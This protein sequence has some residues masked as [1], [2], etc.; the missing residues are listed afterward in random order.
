MRLVLNVGEQRGAAV[1]VRRIAHR[2]DHLC[3]RRDDRRQN[4]EEE[5]QE[6]AEGSGCH[7]SLGRGRRRPPGTS[8]EPRRWTSA[9]RYAVSAP[10][11]PA[12][13]AP[14]HPRRARARPGAAVPPR[15]AR[16]R[17][18]PAPACRR[19]R[20]ARRAT[21]LRRR[22]R[23]QGRRARRLARAPHRAAMR[24][25]ALRRAHAPAAPGIRLRH[26]PHHRPGRRDEH[27]DLC[28]SRMRCS[29]GRCRSMRRNRWSSC[30]H[31]TGRRA[32]ARSRSASWRTTA[33]LPAS[34]RS[35]SCTRCGSSCCRRRAGTAIACRSACRRRSSRR[36]TFRCS[37]CARGWGG[38]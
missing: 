22:R 9:Q 17:R 18:K 12:V 24:R 10:A 19:P 23:H 33:R 11:A 2:V 27:R 16:R 26:H 29:C 28:A 8:I 14:P 38:C 36:T 37:A 7:G 1:L 13:G 35:P 4:K 3:A 20:R 32:A 6:C 34:T 25:R 21:G 5:Q 31:G 30:S 15:H